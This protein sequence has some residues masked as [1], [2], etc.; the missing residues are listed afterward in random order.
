MTKLRKECL[1]TVGATA[2]FE[3]LIQA[4]LSD[5]VLK[6]LKEKGFTHLNFQYGNSSDLFHEL[7]EL[8]PQFQRELG[9]VITSFGFE[10]KGLGGHIKKCKQVDGESE[11]GLVI[12]HAGKFPS[13]D[14][15]L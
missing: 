14:A 8:L 6:T 1:V 4:T 15:M 7:Y 12:S 5:D 13:S 11:E 9:F 2:T 10:P 3:H